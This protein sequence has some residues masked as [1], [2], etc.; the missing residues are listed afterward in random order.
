LNLECIRIFNDNQFFG[1]VDIFVGFSDNTAIFGSGWI[2]PIEARGATERNWY[3]LA[4]DVNGKPIST[5]IFKDSFT[6]EMAITI[7]KHLGEING[8]DAV[9]AL[10]LLIPRKF[11]EAIDK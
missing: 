2:P 9:L 4:I 7:A 11:Y 1:L 8:L 3:R 6:W 5:D 10:N